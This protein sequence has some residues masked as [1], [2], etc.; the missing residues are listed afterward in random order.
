[1]TNILDVK[2]KLVHPDAK[3][4]E[5]KT[6]GA[7]GFDLH[8]VDEEV[9]VEPIQLIKGPMEKEELEQAQNLI[10]DI[11]L[12]NINDTYKQAI[13]EVFG[14][15][16]LKKLIIDELPKNVFQTTQIKT[17]SV[18][19]D[20]GVAFEIPEGYEMQIRGR[21]GLA[22]KHNIEVHRGTI[23]SDYRGTVKVKLYNLGNEPVVLRKGDRIAQGVIQPVVKAKFET[24][25][26]LSETDRGTGGFGST[27][28]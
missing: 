14:E 2:I 11:F 17:S 15:D 5:Y 18:V 21:S 1:M 19:V 3:V 26:E 28:R 10:A 8:M 27:G 6:D 16:F 23:D 12:D 9:V 4:P 13:D 24:V 25:S 20:T 7:A 22:F